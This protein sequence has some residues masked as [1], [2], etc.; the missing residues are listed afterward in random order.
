MRITRHEPDGTENEY[1]VRVNGQ[2]VFRGTSIECR[3][4]TRHPEVDVRTG[5]PHRELVA[6]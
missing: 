5:L 2:V 4:R 3:H 1:V 6:A